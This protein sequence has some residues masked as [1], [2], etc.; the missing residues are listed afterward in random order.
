MKE[1]GRKIK[2]TSVQRIHVIAVLFISIAALVLQDADIEAEEPEKENAE[3]QILIKTAQ[4]SLKR[5]KR[6]I[7]KD[8]FFSARVALNV[9]RINAVAAGIFEKKQYDE[10]KNKIYQTSIEKNLKWFEEF[11]S[12]K[13]YKDAGICL[14]VWRMHST[15]IDTFDPA[16]YESLKERLK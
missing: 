10:F 6:A 9:W 8:G 1:N 2:G 4:D 7:K 3:Q 16:L 12:Q 11:V 5:L 13:N 14:E 15:T